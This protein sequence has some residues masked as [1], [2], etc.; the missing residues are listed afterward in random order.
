MERAASIVTSLGQD[1]ATAEVRGRATG[2]MARLG[3]PGVGRVKM[4]ET[5][6]EIAP[7][8]A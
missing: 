4:A 3:E 1:L 7:R 8:P 2:K 5:C 6:T